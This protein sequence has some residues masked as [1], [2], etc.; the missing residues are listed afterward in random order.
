M[1]RH[2]G[3][4][5]DSAAHTIIFHLV[6]LGG[7]A[8]KDVLM[9]RLASEY[10][11]K[12]IAYSDF[13]MKVIDVLERYELVVISGAIFNVTQKGKDYVAQ[14]DGADSVVVESVGKVVPPRTVPLFR[15]LNFAR[16]CVVAAPREGA[17][18]H[19]D[20]PSLM[21]GQRIFPKRER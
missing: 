4:R 1:A 9:A 15:T 8:A 12:N 16:Y 6:D 11:S 19:Q 18:T 14:F 10:P 2:T 17:F 13:K 7:T 21:C 20:M 5:V 3:P